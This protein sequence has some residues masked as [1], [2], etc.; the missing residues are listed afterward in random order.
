MNVEKIVSEAEVNN[1]KNQKIEL[2]CMLEHGGGSSNTLLNITG[3][4]NND[5]SNKE[6]IMKL[7]NEINI[8]NQ[9]ITLLSQN[10]ENDLKEL[11]LAIVMFKQKISKLEEENN[12]LSA[13]NKKEN[14]EN[15][16]NAENDEK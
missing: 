1:L 5:I 2:Q 15:R 13:R 10:H 8:K 4:S 9:Q 14:N 12:C 7:E 16:E 11:N 6:K 3:I